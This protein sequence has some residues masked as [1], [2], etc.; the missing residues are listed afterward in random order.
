MNATLKER[1]QGEHLHHQELF[2]ALLNRV[3]AGDAAGSQ[4]AWTAFEQ[5]MRAHMELEEAEIL[6]LFERK[7]AEDA[8]LVRAEHDRIRLLLSDMGMGLDLHIVREEKVNDL[9]QFLKRHAQYENQLLY[10]WAS[11]ELPEGQRQTLLD[12]LKGAVV[13]GAMAVKHAAQDTKIF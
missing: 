12:R 13:S 2:D 1:L 11:E 3:H 4:E 9:V 5:A 10:A 7:N 8:A 6:P